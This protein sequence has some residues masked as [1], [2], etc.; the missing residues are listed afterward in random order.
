MEERRLRGDHYKFLKRRNQID[1]DG[2]FSVVLGN[3]GRGDGQ[4]M[5]TGSSI[6]TQGRTS[7]LSE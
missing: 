3:R 6:P 2:L 4:K 5:N 7:L 1:R